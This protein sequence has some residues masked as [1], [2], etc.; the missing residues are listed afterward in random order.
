MPVDSTEAQAGRR[1]GAAHAIRRWLPVLVL[2]LVVGGATGVVAQMEG[3]P[4]TAPPVGE[5]TRSETPVLSLR[6]NLGPLRG[7]AADR[8]LRRRLD[9]FVASQPEDTCLRVDAEGV[10]YDHRTEDPQAPASLQKIVTAVAVL[11]ELGPEETFRTDV[12]SAPPVDG[13]VTG[14]LYVRGGGDPLLATPQYM[15]RERNQPQLFSNVD[16]LADAVVAAGVKVVT[17]SVVGDES[18]YDT[19]RYD[20]SL[21]SR[22]IGQGQVG[23]ASAL[24]VNDGFAHYPDATGVFG[25]AP[26]PAAYAATVVHNALA[27]RGVVIAGPPTS[28]PAPD[29]STVTVSRE[30][31]PVSAVVAQMLRESDNN[32]AELLVKEIG[33]R[34]TGEGSFAAGSAAVVAILDEAG[35][36]VTD[37]AVADGSGLAPDNLVTCHAIFRLLEHPPTADLVR[38]SL[39][40]AGRSGT[41]AQRWVDT[42]LAGKVRAKTGTL[43]T[44]TGLAGFVDTAAGDDATFAVLA[45]V[46]TGT[47]DGEMIAAQ[48]RLVEALAAHPDLPEIDHLRPGADGGG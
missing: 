25:A 12:L 18:R 22:F 37:L 35:I 23:P 42:D 32:T 24:S 30:S 39:A 38:T 16:E 11:T 40:V 36:D 26:D 17:G 2:V 34:R 21:P 13:L 10:E 8:T 28:G 47:I 5:A 7:V 41:L 33:F 1:R 48:Q 15:A 9:R 45:N 27:A 46:A 44:V 14:N 3:P 4:S 43:N 31:P 6:R 19:E 20:P 29:G